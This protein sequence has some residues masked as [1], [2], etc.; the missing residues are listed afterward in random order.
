ML[1]SQGYYTLD[2]KCIYDTTIGE[3]DMFTLRTVH[4]DRA[5]VLCQCEATALQS[6]MSGTHKILEMRQIIVC[7]LVI[8]RC[9]LS[10]QLF[11]NFDD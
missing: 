9:P 4:N 1:S 10:Q 6:D 3:L 8:T 7:S 11:S 5:H 2:M